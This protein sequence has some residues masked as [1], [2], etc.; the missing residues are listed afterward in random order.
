MMDFMPSHSKKK[1]HRKVLLQGAAAALFWI[2]IWEILSLFIGSA[3]ILPSPLLTIQTLAKMMTEPD[4]FSILLV[5]L[6]RV[7]GGII[8]SCFLAFVLGIISGLYEPVRILFQPFASVTRTLPVV[9]VIIL[10][11]LWISSGWVPLVVTFLMCFPIVW[12]NTVTGILQTGSSLLEMAEVFGV[13]QRKCLTGIYLP[14]VKP[15]FKTA[16][17]NAVGMSWKATVTAEVLANARP[18][19]GMSLYYAKVYLETPRLFAWTLLLILISLIL[20]KLTRFLFGE[21]RH[22][23]Y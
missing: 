5:T 15:Y 4:F 18:S 13:S 22:D 7:F 12:S 2:L 10:I 20:E 8:G 21:R 19:V 23:A 16:V 11:N 17:M 6:V 1:K 9:S 14:S 3:L